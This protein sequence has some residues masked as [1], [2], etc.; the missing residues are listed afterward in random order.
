LPGKILKVSPIQTSAILQSTKE[1][2]V[3]LGA[4]IN[5]NVG[6]VALSMDVEGAAKKLTIKFSQEKMN[7][8]CIFIDIYNG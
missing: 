7:K 6:L 1:L 3:I 5:L 4:G 2:K 8:I